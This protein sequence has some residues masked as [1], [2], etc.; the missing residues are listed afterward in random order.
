LSK[1]HK[2]SQNEKK[3]EFQVSGCKLAVLGNSWPGEGAV[4]REQKNEACLRRMKRR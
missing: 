3:Y 4:R 1:Q 2:S